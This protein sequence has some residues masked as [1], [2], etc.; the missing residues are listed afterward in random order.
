MYFS[1]KI[2]TLYYETGNTYIA[3]IGSDDTIRLFWEREDADEYQCFITFTFD[4]DMA[5]NDVEKEVVQIIEA[6]QLETE[7]QLKYAEHHKTN[8]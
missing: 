4:N 3:S 2:L 5:L 1:D 7:E 8:F 6:Q